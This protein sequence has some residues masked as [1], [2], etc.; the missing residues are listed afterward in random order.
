[1]SKESSPGV[2]DATEAMF[3]DLRRKSAKVKEILDSHALMMAQQSAVNQESVN[4]SE[5]QTPSVAG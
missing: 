1:M 5:R 3:A 4:L 2:D